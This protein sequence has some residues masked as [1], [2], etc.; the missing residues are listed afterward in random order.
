M[1]SD[2][3]LRWAIANGLFTFHAGSPSDWLKMT[4]RYTMK[5]LAEKISCPTLI[6]DSEGDKFMPGQARKLF[7]ALNCPKEY[8]LFTRQEGAQEHCQMGAV[9]I[10][11]ARILDWLDGLMRKGKAEKPL[12]KTGRT[13]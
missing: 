4:R 10:S 12:V 2:P 3:S 8:M 13:N 7:E 5:D 9:L 6:V 11:N 1:K